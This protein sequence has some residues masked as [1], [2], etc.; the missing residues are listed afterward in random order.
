MVAQGHR[1]HQ[2]PPPASQQAG[3]RQ[4]RLGRGGPAFGCHTQQPAT[5]LT[6]E[7]RRCLG[8]RTS[9]FSLRAHRPG[10]LQKQP[11]S[12]R[13]EEYR[14]GGSKKEPAERTRGGGSFRRAALTRVYFGENSEK[15]RSGG[16][17]DALGRGKRVLAV[18][19]LGGPDIRKPADAVPPFTPSPARQSRTVVRDVGT[20]RRA[21]CFTRLNSQPV[22]AGSEHGANILPSPAGSTENAHF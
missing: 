22:P 19:R 13:N 6:E 12:F 20:C 11:S 8:D 3:R 15:E 10:R 1:E 17:R 2:N 5:P 4:A 16:I 9:A 7:S 18:R 14:W 21:D